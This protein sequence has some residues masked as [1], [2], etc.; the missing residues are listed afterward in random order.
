MV[1]LTTYHGQ[2]N[3]WYITTMETVPLKKIYGNFL[4]PL[5]KTNGL[6]TWMKWTNLFFL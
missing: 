5:D 3:K 2:Q 6:R 4:S 1:Y